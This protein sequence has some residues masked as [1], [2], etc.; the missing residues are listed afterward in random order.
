MPPGASVGGAAAGA[1]RWTLTQ[2]RPCATVTPCGAAPTSTVDSTR[3]VCG[4]IRSRVPLRLFATHTAPAPAAT[5][6]GRRPTGMVWVTVA[7]RG[8][9][10]E[11]VPSCVFATHT[12]PAPTA[13]AVGPWPTDVVAT[14]AP[15]LAGSIRVTVLSS[16]SVTQTPPAPVAMALGSFPTEIV[17]VTSWLVPPT[18]ATAPYVRPSRPRR[19]RSPWGWSQAGRIRRNPARSVPSAPRSESRDRG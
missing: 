6:V 10:R 15:S 8:S 7:V 13:T 1:L 3:I 12:A 19:S 4:S 16:A 5:R 9:I 14:T 18:R 11:T 17:P 2:T